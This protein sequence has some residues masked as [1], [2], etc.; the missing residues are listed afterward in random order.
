[1]TAPLHYKGV[2]HLIRDM[3]EQPRHRSEQRGIADVSR[4][5]TAAS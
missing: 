4:T 1:M 5:F 3:P 2:H